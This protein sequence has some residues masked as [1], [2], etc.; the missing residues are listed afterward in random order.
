M[1]SEVERANRPMKLMAGGGRP[2]LIAGVR[3]TNEGFQVT[4]RE[5]SEA[6]QRDSVW[7]LV[8]NVDRELHQP[9]GQNQPVSGTH[10]YAPGA[11]VYWL[12]SNSYGDFPPSR[13]G[14]TYVLGKH[15]RS[16]RW[17]RCWIL[18]NRIVSWRI[19]VIYKPRILRELC[20]DIWFT[21]LPDQFVWTA[22]RDTPESVAALLNHWKHVASAE[23]ERRRT[24]LRGAVSLLDDAGA[25][26]LSRKK[27]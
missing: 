23:M 24:E 21:F 15:R 13:A 9:Q 18:S 4:A 17:L 14:S 2:Q 6:P 5:H 11:R 22:K 1:L 8:G 7:A 10:I 20:D 12:A 16:G 27:S 25:L 26:S 3:R 19:S